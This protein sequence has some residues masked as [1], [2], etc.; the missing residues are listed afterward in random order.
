MIE[1][2]IY[3][4]NNNLVNEKRINQNRILYNYKGV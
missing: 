4:N 3:N 2:V 1:T